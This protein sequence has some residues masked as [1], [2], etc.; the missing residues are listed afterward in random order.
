MSDFMLA[1]LQQTAERSLAP[2]LPVSPPG[3]PASGE[4]LLWC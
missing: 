4:D 1:G 3:Q 2:G